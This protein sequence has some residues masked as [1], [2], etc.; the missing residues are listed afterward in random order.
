ME[1]SPFW[2]E[3]I[4]CP[5]GFSVVEAIA[6]A[7]AHADDDDDLPELETGPSGENPATPAQVPESPP[8][9]CPAPP[10]SPKKL[11]KNQKKNLRGRQ[12]RS[13]AR[14]LRG[15]GPKACSLKYRASAKTRPLKSD[16]D[17]ARDLPHSKPAWVGLRKIEDD[18]NVYGLAELQ[19]TYG[20]R[21]FEWDGRWVPL[22]LNGPR[23]ED[24]QNHSPNC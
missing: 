6:R 2:G 20:L 18:Q 4:Q 3:P 17:L 16:V 14:E 5:V 15:S 21:L 23:T 9:G 10:P 7:E 13:A 22:R 11:T 24:A 8:P 12:V 19:D 1:F